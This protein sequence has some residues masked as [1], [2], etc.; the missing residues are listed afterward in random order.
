MAVLMIG[1]GGKVQVDVPASLLPKGA[2]AGD[3]LRL[4]ISIDSSSR[5]KA[6]ERVKE[7][8]EELKQQSGTEEQKDFKL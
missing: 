2:S 8:Q 3:H 6:E 5:A 1:E 4:T 7:L